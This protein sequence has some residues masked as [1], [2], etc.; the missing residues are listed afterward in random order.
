M[1]KMKRLHSRWL[2]KAPHHLLPRIEA[3]AKKNGCWVRV[4]KNPCG[5]EGVLFWIETYAD[6]DAA[7]RAESFRADWDTELQNWFLFES[8]GRKP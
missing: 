2:E 4:W 6:G 8:L 7:G 5:R 1:E 3:L